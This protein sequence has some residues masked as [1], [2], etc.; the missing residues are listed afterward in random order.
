[1]PVIAHFRFKKMYVQPN[2]WWRV[3]LRETT[4]NRTSFYRR[5]FLF[6]VSSVMR[7]SRAFG[8]LCLAVWF[9]FGNTA[10]AQV[11]I[12]DVKF[13]VNASVA[14]GSVTVTSTPF[15]LGSISKMFDGDT[16][17]LAR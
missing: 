2:P 1:M 9:L 3:L 6:E 7:L 16:N 8:S 14:A 5:R 10:T 17:S 12:E 11:A 15:D 4:G 13:D